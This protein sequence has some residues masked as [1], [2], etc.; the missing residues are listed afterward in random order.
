METALWAVPQKGA[1]VAEDG[2]QACDPTMAGL[3][4]HLKNIKLTP[5]A[6]T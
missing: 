4:E 1:S 6:M 2:I 3:A 5:Q